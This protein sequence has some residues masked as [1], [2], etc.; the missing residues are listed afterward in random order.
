VI[1]EFRR[2]KKVRQLGT[3]ILRIDKKVANG[4]RLSE[5]ENW[6][7]AKANAQ[8]KAGNR[9]YARES[10]VVRGEV[11]KEWGLSRPNGAAGDDILEDDGEEEGE[12][13]DDSIPV[14]QTIAD[15]RRALALKN[16]GKQQSKFDYMGNIHEADRNISDI[17]DQ[18]NK[19]RI[20]M[21][22]REGQEK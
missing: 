7:F 22:L 11:K 13:E 10:K 15:K 16:G 4:E 3:A 12:E 2:K 1:K 21:L 20:R 18:Q 19:V 9:L 5:E 17:D 6:L 14:V 8:A